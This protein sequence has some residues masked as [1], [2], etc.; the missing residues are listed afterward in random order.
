MRNYN[1]DRCGRIK[2]NQFPPS[3]VPLYTSNKPLGAFYLDLQTIRWGVCGA[4]TAKSASKS[5]NARYM[6]CR[7]E[8]EI[9]KSVLIKQID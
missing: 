7:Y 3:T 9:L 2:I 5:T 6:I 4:P 8:C 1:F